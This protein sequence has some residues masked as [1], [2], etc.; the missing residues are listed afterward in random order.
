MRIV[1][2]VIALVLIKPLQADDFFLSACDYTLTLSGYVAQ[3]GVDSLKAITVREQPWTLFV[4]CTPNSR[5]TSDISEIQD[6]AKEN[7]DFIR[8][9]HEFDFSNGQRAAIF[10]NTTRTNPVVRLEGYFAT[11]DFEYRFVF[12]PEKG[13]T[14]RQEHWTAM[15]AELQSIISAS[16]PGKQSPALPEASYRF[17]LSMFLAGLA[18]AIGILSFFALRSILRRKKQ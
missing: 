4:V 5:R 1:P 8:G 3:Q 6:R 14:L 2:L 7:G 11:R 9:Y 18:L 12:V 16:R 17:R 15:E 13:K 10:R